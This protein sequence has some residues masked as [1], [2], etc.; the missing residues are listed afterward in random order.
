MPNTGVF[1]ELTPDGYTVTCPGTDVTGHGPT[2]TA[3][4]SDF[5]DACH[6]QWKPPAP[7]PA[8]DSLNGPQRQRKIRTLRVRDL[9]G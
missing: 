5:W 7:L 4:W 1:V 2:E 3:A 6:A 9:F 8:P